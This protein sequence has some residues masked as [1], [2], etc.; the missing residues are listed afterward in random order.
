MCPSRA[1]F[2]T[3]QYA[4]NHHVLSNKAPT[5]GYSKLNHANTL[6]V[7]LRRAGYRTAFAGKYL[8]G[9]PPAGRE[10]EIPPGWAD[11][12]GATNGI[13]N[14]STSTASASS[15]ICFGIQMS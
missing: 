10:L 9:Y 15:T 4:H 6:A 1:T 13:S 14:S 2:L 3:G 7:W 5:G 8:N 11:W 12:L